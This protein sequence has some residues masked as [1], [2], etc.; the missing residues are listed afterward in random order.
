MRY[1]TL[2][3]R[4]IFDWVVDHPWNDFISAGECAVDNLDELSAF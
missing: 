3:L 1:H 4:F 2:L